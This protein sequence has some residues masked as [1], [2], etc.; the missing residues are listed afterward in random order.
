MVVYDL[1]NT[2][3]WFAYDQADLHIVD[4]GLFLL[5]MLSEI[6]ELFIHINSAVE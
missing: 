5:L 3:I 2:H 6:Q 4:S 1:A